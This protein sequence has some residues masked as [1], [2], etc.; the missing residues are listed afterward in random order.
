MI[1]IKLPK[2]RR[3]NGLFLFCNKCKRHFTDDNQL[4]HGR[5]ECEN[6]SFLNYKAKIHVPGTLHNVKVKT[7]KATNFND[8]INEFNDFK[9]T[10]ER[11]GY[12]Q[13]EVVKK[14]T[15]T[16][17]IDCM[18]EYLC[19]LKDVNVYEHKVK[20]LS[21]EH[22]KEVM[23][24]FEYVLNVLETKL[25]NK[26]QFLFESINDEIVGWIHKYLLEEKNYQASTYN[27]FMT[28]MR[29]F[30]RY[31]LEKHELKGLEYFNG[32][33]RKVIRK[34]AVSV[35]P[36]DLFSLL[37]QI[38]IENGKCTYSKGPSKNL[39]QPWLKNAILL[40]F[41]TGR[42]RE[43]ILT[44]K[45]K[46]IIYSQHTNTPAYI[47]SPNL[48]VNRIANNDDEK[49]G[50][51]TLIPINK[52]FMGFLT[53]IGHD[54][55]KPEEY[56]IAPECNRLRRTM[57]DDLSKGFSH[58]YRLLNKEDNLQL[59]NLRKTFTTLA[60][61][62]LGSKAY[63]ATGHSDSSVLDKFYT[64][65]LLKAENQKFDLLNSN[66]WHTLLSKM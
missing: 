52:E 8:A 9:I 33:K 48:K 31:I 6:G 19:F 26:E 20:N 21:S 35:R 30:A 63:L 41:F 7:L 66:E 17:L 32:V 25:K 50:I 12:N 3:P 11:Y 58:Y 49:N 44:M 38:T 62:K 23:R 27:K 34:G 59:K 36:E 51:Y 14:N 61:I 57:M 15:P 43:E 39:F 2:K 5:M 45:N 56:L 46:H 54:P 42:R 55:K 37:D 60:S 18:A 22:I 47:K 24:Y 10:L 13:I 53:K 28:T 65:E 40:V 64:D 4:K 16:K 29:T 1:K